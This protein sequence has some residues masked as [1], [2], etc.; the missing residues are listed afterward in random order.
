MLKW[1][2]PPR[3]ARLERIH[4]KEDDTQKPT[5]MPISGQDDKISNKIPTK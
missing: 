1:K 5:S 4:Q 2:T 3:V